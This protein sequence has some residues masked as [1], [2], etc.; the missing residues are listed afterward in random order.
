MPSRQEV[1]E[2]MRVLSEEIIESLRILF[3]MIF[4]MTRAV[5]PEE[6][7]SDAEMNP[8]HQLVTGSQS[9]SQD[10]R[11][12]K[13]YH[14]PFSAESSP[15][16]R[17]TV[18][19]PT[20]QCDDGLRV[21]GRGR[22]GS[23]R[24]RHALGSSCAPLTWSGPKYFPAAFH[25]SDAEPSSS[26]SGSSSQERHQDCWNSHS[27]SPVASQ[28]GS[29]HTW[30]RL[31]IELK[32]SWSDRPHPSSLGSLGSQ[33]HHV[34]TQTHGKDLCGNLRF[35]PRL[36][37]VD[38]SQDG[39]T[40]RRDGGLRQLCHHTTTLGRSSNEA[41][42]QLSEWIQLPEQPI[43][44]AMAE[45]ANSPLFSHEE[46]TCLQEVDKLIKR[47]NST[48]Q[49]LDL[50]EVYAYPNSQLTEVAIAS[51][52]R[53]KRFT[54]EDGDLSTSEGR[55]NL[56]M[57]IMLHKPKHVW[58]A[59]ECGPWCAWNRFNSM[60]SPSG[61]QRVMHEQ[62]MAVTHLKLCNLI[63]K[64]QVSEGRHVHLENPWTSGVWTQKTLSDL[65][66]SS[67][68]AQLDQC[69]FG[70]KHPETCDPMQ[71][72]TRVQTTSKAMFQ[73]LDER[74]CTKE[75]EHIPIAGTCQWKGFSI[76][77]CKYAGFY[78]KRFA[79]AI[80]L[81]IIKTK[82]PPMEVP[83]MHV[84]SIEPPAKRQ[85]TETE[86]QLEETEDP[87]STVL[88]QLKQELPK[89]GVQTW[90]NPMH[91]IFQ[92]V[93]ALLPK[94]QVGAI[95]AGKGLE[96]YIPGDADWVDDLPIRYTVSLKRFSHEVIHLGNEDWSSLSKLAQHRKAIPS[97]SQPYFTLC[98][99]FQE[100][101]WRTNSSTIAWH[102]RCSYARSRWSSRTNRRRA[103]KCRCSDMDTNGSRRSW[104]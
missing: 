63:S 9:E 52:L 54:Q 103:R 87:W 84:D 67:V 18:N 98:V 34:G 66:Q 51:G 82:D 81:G 93:Q 50:L 22:D 41:R 65:L 40:Q 99:R 17:S 80:V 27:C 25:T 95:R 77:V 90:T 3:C 49:Q 102:S 57:Q 79:K 92:A 60:R 19:E 53:A 64:L 43:N 39:L 26:S 73:V 88:E 20:E 38:P 12:G 83:V 30:T 24:A 101:K 62:Q 100:N 10:L 74:R 78:P 35:R 70:L 46:I 85:K 29:C 75:H 104:T 33:E 47:G 13:D 68:A 16:S 11:V 15:E 23:S 58:L 37:Q 56:L 8:I 28:S 36:H 72:C 71:K 76:K 48:C 97:I 2:A 69:M 1:L 42:S 89:S 7:V 31:P 86:T 5:Q 4:S 14:Q 6:P 55:T 44:H 21:V 59:P 32:Q 61:F 94:Y 91:P 45:P 96:R